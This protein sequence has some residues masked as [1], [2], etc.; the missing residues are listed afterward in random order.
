MS[1]KPDFR[2]SSAPDGKAWKVYQWDGMGCWTP[3]HR[4]VNTAD[5]DLFATRAEAEAL[6][7]RLREEAEG[8]RK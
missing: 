2:I 3:I 8:I 1:A 7:K 4:P 6:V 5:S